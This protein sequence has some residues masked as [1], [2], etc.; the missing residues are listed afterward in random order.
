MPRTHTKHLRLRPN[1][2]A[3]EP[4]APPPV[5]EFEPWMKHMVFDTAGAMRFLG[6]CSEAHLHRLDLPLRA[7]HQRPG[8]VRLLPRRRARDKG[9][10]RC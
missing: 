3:P 10:W 7:G 1:G 8:L 4:V 9:H 5:E 6:N 2:T